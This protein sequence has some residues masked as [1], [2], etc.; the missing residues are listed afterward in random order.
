M[1]PSNGN[2]FISSTLFETHHTQVSGVCSF[3]LKRFLTTKLREQ[4]QL[5]IRNITGSQVINYSVNSVFFSLIHARKVTSNKY[6][7]IWGSVM[8]WCLAI[9]ILQSHNTITLQ[10]STDNNAVNTA[11]CFSCIHYIICCSIIHK[12]QCAVSWL[13]QNT[14]Q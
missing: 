12:W 5:R 4:W 1:P 3:R 6:A 2:H 13:S 7:S 14:H 8:T 9:M 10:S 11:I